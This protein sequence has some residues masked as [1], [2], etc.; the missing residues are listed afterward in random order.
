MSAQLPKL[1]EVERVATSIIRILG[2]N[3]G[4]FTLLGV[5]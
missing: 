1:Q 2:G 5:L 4:N 3:P